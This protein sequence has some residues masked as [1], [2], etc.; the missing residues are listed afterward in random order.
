M[1]AASFLASMAGIGRLR[2][3]PGT[4]GS[5]LVLP[6]AWS[7]PALCLAAAILFSA[8]GV[9]AI[10]RLPEA[11]DDPSWVVIDEGAGQSLALAALPG[12][13]TPGWTAPI[14]VVGAFVLFRFFDIVKPWPVS[15]ADRRAGAVWVMVDD[16][17]AGALAAA[18]LL[19]MRIVTG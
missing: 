11:R 12:F 13:W 5:A 6:L 19:A 3:A 16:L 7:S 17:V 1:T 15:W 18:C 9:W 2:P 14:W 8:L 10:S 4:W